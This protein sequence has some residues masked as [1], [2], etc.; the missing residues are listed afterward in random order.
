MTL[1]SMGSMIGAPV[2]RLLAVVLG[3]DA[4]QC[5]NS[6]DPPYNGWLA[7]GSVD[8]RPPACDGWRA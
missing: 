3:G 8:Q 7:D 1:G 6:P 2:D 4:I 5:R